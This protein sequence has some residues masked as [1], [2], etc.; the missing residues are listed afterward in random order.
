MNRS[1]RADKTYEQLFLNKRTASPTDPEFMEILQRNIF[2][3]TFYTGN[4]NN[5]ER[6]LITVA[7]LATMQTLP[8]LKAHIG[9]ALNAG[10][11]P[12]EIRETIY[13]CAPFIGFPR[14][15]NAI[16]VFNEVAKERNIKLPL[17]NAGTTTE[18]DRH[19]K[20]LA[21][22]TKLYGDEVKKAMAPLPGEYKDI[23]P[24]T[25]TDFCFGDFYTRD[26]LTIQQRELLSLVGL[27]PEYARRYPHQFSGGQRQRIGIA[28]ALA[29]N[30]RFIVADEPVS[31]LDV[32]VQSQIVNLLQDIQK[33]TRVAFLFIAHDLAVVEHISHRIM[34]MY[35]GKL[36]ETGPARE[37]CSRPAHPY[38]KALLSSV[39]SLDPRHK[40]GRIV[41]KGD[42][43][44]PLDPP[45]GC[46]FHPRC[47]MRGVR[48]ET[49][50]PVLRQVPGASPGHCS[51]CHFAERIS[52]FRG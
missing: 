20:G 52:E 25:L 19:E 51:A 50:E 46:R 43:P 32:S 12:L 21:L 28:R 33:Q 10:N 41:L 23:V 49:E 5:K 8:Q 4:L 14:T 18:A 48:C 2:G 29:V 36:A 9:A 16:G 27:K 44:S 45:K 30:P 17:E 39:P 34:V 6:E 42:V 38:T 40:T 13:Q 26:G 47:P 11:S 37:L 15:L 22:Q 31:A 7:A 3:E 24:D 1:E 35:L